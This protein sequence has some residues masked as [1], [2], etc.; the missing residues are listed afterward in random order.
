MQLQHLPV[1]VHGQVLFLQKVIKL[2]K[3]DAILSAGAGVDALIFS[4]VSDH[5]HQF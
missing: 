1:D 3:V 2:A 5:F 4:D